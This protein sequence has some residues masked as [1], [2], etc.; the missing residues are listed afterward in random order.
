MPTGQYIRMELSRRLYPDYGLTGK[1]EGD[2]SGY[3]VATGKF[4][5]GNV[6]GKL[7]W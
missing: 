3:A 4:S 7:S 2:Y 6:F 1:N 5:D